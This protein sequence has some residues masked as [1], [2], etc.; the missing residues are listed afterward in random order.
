MQQNF[1]IKDCTELLGDI[2]SINCNSTGNVLRKSHKS[3]VL[4]YKKKA[5]EYSLDDYTQIKEVTFSDELYQFTAT[6]SCF[7]VGLFRSSLLWVFCWPKEI[8]GTT[9]E[10]ES[11]K[12]GKN[13]QKEEGSELWKFGESA[14][15]KWPIKVR[16][17]KDSWTGYHRYISFTSRPDIFIIL[18]NNSCVIAYQICP[19]TNTEYQLKSIEICPKQKE[20]H[21]EESIEDFVISGKFLYTLKFGGSLN[22]IDISSIIKGDLNSKDCYKLIKSSAPLAKMKDSSSK[23]KCFTSISCSD[24][25]LFCGFDLSDKKVGFAL[26]AKQNLKLLDQ[27]ELDSP[28]D[29]TQKIEPA[30]LDRLQCFWALS[31]REVINLFAVHRKR[32]ICLVKSNHLCPYANNNCMALN[33]GRIIIMS[34]DS[35]NNKEVIMYRAEW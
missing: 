30:N 9:Y 22:K 35:S 28:Q 24:K 13:Y 11:T 7:V 31:V 21:T 32:I 6:S 26:Y 5:E 20:N 15:I 4:A 34:S 23:I 29:S 3:F 33:D 16:Y 17:A 12:W 1:K 2:K 27:I 10:W 19:V 8:D 25:Y 14:T 18:H